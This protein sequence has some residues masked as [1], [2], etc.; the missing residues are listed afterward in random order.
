MTYNLSTEDLEKF[1]FSDVLLYQNVEGV[2]AMDKLPMEKN[3]KKC[4]IVNTDPSFLPG[5]HWI[6]VFIPSNSLPEFFDSLGRSPSHYSE[7]ILNFLL[8]KNSEGFVYNC[9][10]LQGPQTSTCGLFCLYFLYF[11]IRG[12]S[13]VDILERF[14]LNL[15]HNEYIVTEFYSQKT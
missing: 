8:N 3:S 12:Y 14:G 9:K 11:R 7:K 10:R 5:K 2:F 1:L 6:A 15:N 13:F 4:F